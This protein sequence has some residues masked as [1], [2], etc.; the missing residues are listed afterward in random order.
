[1]AKPSPTQARQLLET[2]T[3]PALA[4]DPSQP[5]LPALFA[6]FSAL[7]PVSGLGPDAL[8]ECFIDALPEPVQDEVD[9]LTPAMHPLRTLGHVVRAVLDMEAYG[10]GLAGLNAEAEADVALGRLVELARAQGEGGLEDVVDQFERWSGGVVRERAGEWALKRLLREAL[11]GRWRVEIG[12][13]AYERGLTGGR[14]DFFERSS[15]D[16]LVSWAKA[17]AAAVR[18]EEHE[19][20]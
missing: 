16:E 18:R 15:L 4:S 3:T 8:L 20:V 1:M 13:K 12:L 7:A 9:R 14:M 6:R 10:A 19:S 2:L 5:D 11:P 17:E